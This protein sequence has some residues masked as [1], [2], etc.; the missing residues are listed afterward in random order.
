VTVPLKYAVVERERRFLVDR[1]PDGVSRTARITDRYLIGTRLR[2][3]VTVDHDGV[4]VRKL[5]HKVR[6]T[7]GPREVACTS[8]YLDDS[9][10]AVL[11]ALPAH[12]LHKR[13]HWIEREGVLVVVDEHLDGT[14]VAEIDDGDLPPVDVPTW[15]SVVRDVTH[16][17]A[18]TGAAFARSGAHG[19]A[20]R[21][22]SSLPDGS[23]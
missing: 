5:G 12:V 19:R 16:E 1:L 13:R 22:Q 20:G 9:E 17:E 6:L 7:D 4:V 23:A 18:W 14:L 8:M 2:I 11:T 10:W 3:R 15:L 21:A